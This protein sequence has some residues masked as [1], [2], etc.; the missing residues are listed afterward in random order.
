M[1]LHMFLACGPGCCDP[2]QPCV[3]LTLMAFSPSFTLISSAPVVAAAIL[4]K[5]VR[6]TPPA[7]W[8]AAPK[9]QPNARVEDAAVAPQHAVVMD[10][11]VAQQHAVVMDALP[12][13][14]HA[15]KVTIVLAVEAVAD[16]VIATTLLLKC[17]VRLGFHVSRK[18][19]VVEQSVVY[20]AHFVI[21]GRAS[22]RLQRHPHFPP[23]PSFQRPLHPLRRLR[24]HSFLTI[25][26]TRKCARIRANGFR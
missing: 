24:R 9:V 1:V 21:R 6:G 3:R 7:N 16:P 11:A 4:E 10:A 25:S 26:L 17:A 18:R 23:R 14:Q 13:Q 22:P 20:L 5:N 19:H 12:H 15:V 8:P 2:G